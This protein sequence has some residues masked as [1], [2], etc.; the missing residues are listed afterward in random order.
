MGIGETHENNQEEPR[1]RDED[2]GKYGGKHK[3]RFRASQMR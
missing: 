2:K 3:A 1:G